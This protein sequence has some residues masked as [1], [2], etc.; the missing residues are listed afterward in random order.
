MSLKDKFLSKSNSY[1]FYKERNEYLEKQN[2]ELRNELEKLKEEKETTLTEDFFEKYPVAAGFCKWDYV[3]YY[4]RDDFEERLLDVT[5]HLD[6]DSKYRYKLILLRAM[7]VALIRAESLYFPHEREQQKKFLEFRKERSGPNMID[8]YTYYGKYN[9][10]PFIDLNLT[11]K[12]KEFLKDKDIIDAGAFTGDTSIPL[13]PI[14]NKKIYAFEPFEQSFEGLNRN[15]D[16]NKIKNIVPVKKS[17]GN[18]NGE[19]TLYLSGDN[20][21]G[22][23]ANPKARNYDQELKVE[24][25]TVDRF[26]EENNLDVGFITIDVEGAEKDLL[27]GALNTIKTQRPILSISIYHKVTDF[28]EIIPWIADLDLGYEFNVIKEQPWPFLG[29]TVVQCRPKELI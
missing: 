19:R 17:L 29:D 5:K 9:L 18:I 7:A 14:T 23:S 12:D 21:Q 20:Y 11:D 10:H 8:G 4:F 24:E 2:E 15:I 16:A 6:K 3:K 13:S 27:E 1:N 25:V 28:F 22:I 26:V